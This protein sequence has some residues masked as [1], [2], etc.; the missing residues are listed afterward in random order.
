MAA[1]EQTSRKID[2]WP[3]DLRLL[4]LHPGRPRLQNG[5]LHFALGILKLSDGDDDY[6][7]SKVLWNK[8]Y[9]DFK[10]RVASSL[11]LSGLM[12]QISSSSQ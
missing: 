9:V 3:T 2:F 7:V 4:R 11:L 5:V 1:L 10:M 8:N 6:R 12:V